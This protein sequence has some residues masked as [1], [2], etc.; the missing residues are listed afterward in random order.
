METAENIIQ[1]LK[2]YNEQ[3]LNEHKKTIE[4]QFDEKFVQL[5]ATYG[6]PTHDFTE[7]KQV[8]KHV[9]EP[10]LHSDNCNKL[11]DGSS[12]KQLIQ[13]SVEVEY[14]QLAT[15]IRSDGEVTCKLQNKEVTVN[16]CKA[17]HPS[18]SMYSQP[19]VKVRSQQANK[20]KKK[21][22]STAHSN[23]TV[24][25]EID[26]LQRRMKDTTLIA[27]ST[28]QK[29]IDEVRSNSKNSKL[30]RIFPAMKASIDH[31]NM[32]NEDSLQ[33]GK[34]IDASA[35]C[36]LPNI[37][38]KELKEC[39]CLP[40][41]ESNVAYPPNRYINSETIES[42]QNKSSWENDLARHILSV[43]ATTKLVENTK[44][45]SVILQFVDKSSLESTHEMM[46]EGI[47]SNLQDNFDYVDNW[48]PTRNSQAQYIQHSPNER[49]LG[50]LERNVDDL[51]MKGLSKSKA[52][53]RPHRQDIKLQKA[54]KDK[55]QVRAPP[56]VF[57]IWFVSTGDVYADW[58][59]L[60]DGPRLQSY[61]DLLKERKCYK[62]YLLLISE[63]LSECW[64]ELSLSKSKEIKK[65]S[66]HED[67]N[68]PTKSS[69]SKG[70]RSNYDS[71][72]VSQN[73]LSHNELIALWR[74]LVLV[75]NAFATLSMERK[76]FEYS[77][78]LVQLAESWMSRDDIFNSEMQLELKSYIN[79][80]MAN[81]F[82]KKKMAR[83]AY[84][85]SKQAFVI[86]K[87]FRRYDMC[88]V[89]L[90]HM[91]CCDYQISRFKDAHKMIYEFLEL[92][93]QG[94]VAFSETTPQQLCMIAVAYHNL[95]VIQLK[96]QVADAA[97]KSSQNARRI[98]RL[99]LSHSSRWMS[100]F[101][102][103]HQVAVEEVKFQLRSRLSLPEEHQKTIA[104]LTDLIYDPF[105]S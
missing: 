70:V 19:I 48:Q 89:S 74:Q 23:Y 73:L 77:M 82:Y 68:H 34:R 18:L 64:I 42:F 14:N 37:V 47:F 53:N 101:H 6:F 20:M 78:Q 94:E 63:V 52:V 12:R 91:A 9:E 28:S 93:E 59:S 88:A 46:S 98:A 84:S 56:R 22:H 2:E 85:H 90:L 97:C 96:L 57:P 30:G 105:P 49:D 71:L 21:S 55:I 29:L 61:V 58:V 67:N 92:V 27:L 69:S 31:D 43:F 72:L 8:C 45:S 79:S 15:A 36:L 99:C 54:Q 51:T 1:E 102:F 3:V 17:V 40:N 11:N 16:K 60:P 66:P 44:T 87:K 83:A 81:F 7:Q 5:L 104:E 4:K 41:S 76:L 80:T 32:K 103:T 39:D 33:I 86:H 10:F 24:E 100:T 95:A 65:M 35:T 62:E 75:A 13:A 50:L 26:Q 38:T 25:N